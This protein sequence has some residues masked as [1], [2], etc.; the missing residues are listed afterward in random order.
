MK[1]QKAAIRIIGN[2]HFIGHHEPLCKNLSILKLCDLYKSCCLKTLYRWH[3][4]ALP[5]TIQCMFSK[6]DE[7]HDRST[8]SSNKFYIPNFKLCTSRNHI[9]YTAPIIWNNMP[10]HLQATNINFY[11]FNR[12]IKRYFIDSYASVCNVSNC[13]SCNHTASNS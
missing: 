8:R 1:L 12:N 11:T 7:H 6:N 5:S 13:Y 9:Y 2:S 3:K 4:H 10:S